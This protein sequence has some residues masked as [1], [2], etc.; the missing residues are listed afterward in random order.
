MA[1]PLWGAPQI[2]G[3]I[4][5]L[6]IDVN[7]ATVARC[8]Q[9]RP[10]PPSPTWRAFLH[11][12]AANIAAADMFIVATVRF[13]LLYVLVVL[14]HNRRKIIHL[15]V[16][17]HPTDDWLTRQIIE[18]FPWAT[19]SRSLLRDRDAGDGQRFRTRLRAM[20]IEEV[21]TAPRSPWQNPYVERVIGSI[22]R[23][24]LDHLV[25]FNERHLRRVLASYVA[26]Y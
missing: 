20:G 8:M 14:G 10:K 11:N 24:C 13:Q 19:A 22:R 16:T 5:K 1:N 2:H 6:G 18:A 25:I 15:G 9:R 26:Y 12:H 4:R 21:V 23:E 17:R 3:E 7:Q